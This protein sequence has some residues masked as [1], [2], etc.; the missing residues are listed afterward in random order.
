MAVTSNEASYVENI[1]REFDVKLD[2]FRQAYDWLLQNESVTEGDP[3]LASSFTSLMNRAELLDVPIQRAQEAIA[4]LQETI[5]KSVAMFQGLNGLGVLPLLVAGAIVGAVSILGIWL[6]D[7]Y[8]EIN[9]IEERK[10]LLEAGA[11]P[12]VIAR[13]SR[14]GGGW[15]EGLGTLGIVSVFAAGFWFLSNR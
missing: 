11:D 6:S 2:Q 5:D 15:F 14:E 9:K 8:V 10:A 7:A 1:T 12:T 13:A 4:T 3:T